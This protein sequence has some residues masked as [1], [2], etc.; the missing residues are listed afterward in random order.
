MKL[1]RIGTESMCCV[2]FQVTR[3]VDDRDRF[4]WTFLV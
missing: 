1:E 3:Q 2:L 4:E